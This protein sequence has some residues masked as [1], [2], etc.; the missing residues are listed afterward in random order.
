[1]SDALCLY[2]KGE[3][4]AGMVAQVRNDLE[5]SPRANRISLLIDSHGGGVDDAKAI[6]RAIRQ[7]PAATKRATIV[8]QC[9]S[10]A[11]IVLLSADYRRA[12]ANST[13]LLHPT[14]MEPNKLSG[15]RW[16]AARYAEVAARVQRI[17]DEILDLMAERTG[18]SRAALAREDATES[19]TPLPKAIG[20]GLIHAAPGFPS[21]CSSDWPE[22]ARAIMLSGKLIGLSPTQLSPAFMAACRAAPRSTR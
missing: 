21:R 10:A 19:A 1:M 4:N 12:Q 16:T 2:L 3:I 8:N 13:I 20:L 9:C 11:I 6:Y 22:R 7:H 15:R 5:R 17:D 14:E 18:A